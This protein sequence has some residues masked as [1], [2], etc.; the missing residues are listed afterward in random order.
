MNWIIILAGIVLVSVID[1]GIREEVLH[2][3]PQKVVRLT[4]EMFSDG[5]LN[6]RLEK[7]MNKKDIKDFVE[8]IDEDKE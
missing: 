8:V 2:K 3:E 4:L 1:K 7:F 5:K 6:Q